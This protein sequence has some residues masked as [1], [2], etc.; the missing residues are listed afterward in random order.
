MKLNA[1]R[2]VTGVLRGFDP[3]MNLVLDDTIEQSSGAVKNHL[4][5]VV[6]GRLAWTT[7]MLGHVNAGAPYFVLCELCSAFHA[8]IFVKTDHS[9]HI[10]DMKILVRHCS[11]LVV[12][13]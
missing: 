10:F 9:A 7:S 1:G 2:T 6:R 8:T 3:Y 5:M 13:R 4:G 11:S 12:L